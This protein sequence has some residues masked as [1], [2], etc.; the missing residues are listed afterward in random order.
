VPATVVVPIVPRREHARALD[1]VAPPPPR[2]R[3]RRRPGLEVAGAQLP[4]HEDQCALIKRKIKEAFLDRKLGGVSTCLWSS[5]G[6]Q[7]GFDDR[8]HAR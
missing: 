7:A 3:R 5:T 2:R 1:W 4:R 8:C 6:Y